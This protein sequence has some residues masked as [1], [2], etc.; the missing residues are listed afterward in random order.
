MVPSF[1]FGPFSLFLLSFGIK[2]TTIVRKSRK[3]KS[4]R[5]RTVGGDSASFAVTS[6]ELSVRLLTEIRPE[7]AQGQGNLLE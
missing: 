5:K 4:V 3:V 1:S 6:C 2:S 7:P